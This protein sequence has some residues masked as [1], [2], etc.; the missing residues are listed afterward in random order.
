MKRW[1]FAHRN[2][3]ALEVERTGSAA[4]AEAVRNQELAAL[5]TEP[6][7][8]RRNVDLVGLVVAGECIHDDVDAGA[9]G[10]FALAR[11][12]GHRRIEE[13]A[14]RRRRPCGGEIIAGDD[15]RRNIVLKKFQCQ[16]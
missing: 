1:S 6:F 12:G 2:Q 8:Q 4:R 10:Q 16:S 14:V 15:D 7:Q 3:R 9:E 11:I 13:A 5:L